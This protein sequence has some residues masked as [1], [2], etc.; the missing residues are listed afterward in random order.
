MERKLSISLPPA[1]QRLEGDKVELLPNILEKALAR[2]EAKG[3]MA[4]EILGDKF[5][6]AFAISRHHELRV[7]REAVTDW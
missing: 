4:R 5:V 7:W 2:F 1:A 6:D 3:S